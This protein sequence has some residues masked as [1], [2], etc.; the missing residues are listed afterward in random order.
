M[1]ESVIVDVFVA[2]IVGLAMIVLAAACIEMRKIRA[3]LKRNEEVYK[4]RREI[5]MT[6]ALLRCNGVDMPGIWRKW[7]TTKYTY[8]YMMEHTEESVEELAHKL[9]QELGLS[10]S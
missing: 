6:I 3:T 5:I 2:L 7:D 4:T 9:K 8:D 1:S 10:I